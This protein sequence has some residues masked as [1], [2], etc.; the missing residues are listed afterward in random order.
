[1]ILTVA[2]VLPGTQEETAARSASIQKWATILRWSLGLQKW[3]ARST[4]PSKLRP[5]ISEDLPGKTRP[6]V[7]TL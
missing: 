7:D 5:T 3:D 4:E 6:R 2:S 1:V